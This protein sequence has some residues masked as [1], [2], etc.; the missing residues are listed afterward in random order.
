MQAPSF[1]LDVEKL[2]GKE[3][4][5]QFENEIK[6]PFDQ[7]I[8]ETKSMFSFL[9]EEDIKEILLKYNNS[10]DAA[11]DELSDRN[12]QLEEINKKQ[13]LA[14]EEKRRI[15]NNNK[16]IE[17]FVRN[18]QMFEK[19]EIERV[20][21]ENNNDPRVTAQV[22]YNMVKEKEK[23]NEEA[24]K[25]KKEMERQQKL[26]AISNKFPDLSKQ[27]IENVFNNE[28]DMNMEEISF[29]LEIIQ[30]QKYFEDL[31]QLYSDLL[32]S[33]EI[34]Q[35]LDE[36]KWVKLEANRLCKE[37]CSLKIK[38]KSVEIVKEETAPQLKFTEKQI[39]EVKRVSVFKK[40]EIEEEITLEEKIGRAHV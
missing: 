20:F 38:E 2:L 12:S 8:Q 7:I 30:K 25:Q 11:F 5:K 26:N 18:F 17:T 14:L 40:I 32:S 9:T 24:Q 19:S 13:R 31:F 27:Q 3:G 29:K 36:A 28:K 34:T 33:V 22:L 21:I 10:V 4:A 6:D 1:M 37:K 23:Q 16:Y 35:C 15:E 39:E